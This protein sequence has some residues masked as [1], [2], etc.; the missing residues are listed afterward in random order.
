MREFEVSGQTYRAGVIS[1][2]DQFRIVK[3]LVPAVLG[4]MSV[5]DF[6]KSL[7]G[8][9]GVLDKMQPFARILSDM[10]DPDAELILDTCLAVIE[11]KVEGD[12]GWTKIGSSGGL[13]YQDIN[14]AVMM[15]LAYE[16]GR[17]NLEGFFAA[18]QQMFPGVLAPKAA[19][20]S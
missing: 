19:P 16:A 18:L 5:A 1:A 4:L 7:G 3:R 2:R 20:N 14:L 6:A 13:M 12:R 8:D 17:E 9:G 11:R 10:P 15:R